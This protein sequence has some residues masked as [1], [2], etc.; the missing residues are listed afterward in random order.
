MHVH[1]D[2]TAKLLAAKAGDPAAL[3]SLGITYF[4]QRSM[5]TDMLRQRD[6]FGRLWHGQ[7]NAIS[8]AIGYAKFYS[9]SHDAANYL[10]LPYWS[11]VFAFL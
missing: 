5:P 6:F 3:A 11:P 7:P 9:R 8:N 10:C 1:E 4:A 2:F